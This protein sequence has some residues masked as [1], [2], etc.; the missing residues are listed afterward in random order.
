MKLL[1]QSIWPFGRG[2]WLRELEGQFQRR[3]AD[4]DLTPLWI[5]EFRLAIEK[6]CVEGRKG[7]GVWTVEDD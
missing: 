1:G 6:I 7:W 5:I 4:M 3:G 2:V